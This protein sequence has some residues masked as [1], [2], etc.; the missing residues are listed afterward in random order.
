MGLGGR[1]PRGLQRCHLVHCVGSGRS[2][3]L[4]D[5]DS[6]VTRR[7][8]EVTRRGTEGNAGQSSPRH[9]TWHPLWCHAWR[10]F[11][12]FQMSSSQDTWPLLTLNPG[13]KLGRCYLSLLQ[14]LKHTWPC[15]QA[16]KRGLA[17]GGA[18]GVGCLG[19][20][21]DRPPILP[22]P[23]HAGPPQPAHLGADGRGRP[24]LLL[25][26]ALRLGAGAPGSPPAP[27]AHPESVSAGSLQPH[28]PEPQPLLP[29]RCPSSLFPQEEGKEKRS[30][31]SHR[32]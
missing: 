4:C 13:A 10:L 9:I 3:H 11:G 29:S 23:P 19:L 18:A 15:Y 17:W 32:K 6:Q 16:E 21:A 26:V 5:P 22:C 7:W 20:S 1:Q 30:V 12:L 27:P 31:L 8:S 2:L 25:S 24:D 28:G 14:L